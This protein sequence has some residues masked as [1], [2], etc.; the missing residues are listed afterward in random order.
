MLPNLIV[1][2]GSESYH[3]W[4]ET[5]II[6]LLSWRLQE[7]VRFPHLLYRELGSAAPPP[8]PK[9]MWEE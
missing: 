2:V 3:C 9:P 8:P 4:E 7:E 1:L 6:P 5:V